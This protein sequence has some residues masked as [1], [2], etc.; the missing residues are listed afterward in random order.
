VLDVL[1][2]LLFGGPVL[3]VYVRFVAAC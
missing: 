1:D 3:Y 2:S